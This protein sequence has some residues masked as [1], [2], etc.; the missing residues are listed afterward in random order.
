MILT[1]EEITEYED[2]GSIGPSKLAVL[3]ESH[4]TLR[5][6]LNTLQKEFDKLLI[7]FSNTKE[8]LEQELDYREDQEV[9][10][11]TRSFDFRMALINIADH[12]TG[13]AVT[14]AANVLEKHNPDKLVKP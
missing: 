11:K 12:C 5:D 14:I 4:E 8:N 13:S 1:P 9:K 2:M 7:H 6:N 10:A 3:I